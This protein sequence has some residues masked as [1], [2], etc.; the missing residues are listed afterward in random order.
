MSVATA[1]AFTPS[2]RRIA[3][4]WGIPC[5]LS[6]AAAVTSMIVGLYAGLTMGRGPFHGSASVATDFALLSQFPIFNSLLL[7]SRGRRVLAHMAPLGLGSALGTT[8]YATI[9]SWQMLLTFALWSPIDTNPWIPRGG[10]LLAS[11]VAYSAAW[12]LLLKSMADAGLDVQTGFLAWGSVFRGRGPGWGVR[13]T[14][15]HR[16]LRDRACDFDIAI[17]P[18]TVRSIVQDKDGVDVNGFRARYVLAAD[19]LR[20]GVRRRL[21]LE[22]PARHR[23]KRYGLPQH[24][25]LAPWTDVVEVHWHELGEA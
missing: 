24:V 8:T 6:F 9:A 14:D 12:V 4:A 23:V 1:D 5:H 25:R 20:S 15:L 7:S 13:R 10:L 21:G 3:L 11:S 16:A 2:Q 17:L 18:H 22:A 19:G